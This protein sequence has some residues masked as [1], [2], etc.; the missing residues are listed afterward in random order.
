[1]VIAGPTVEILWVTGAFVGGVAIALWWVCFSRAP[2]RERRSAVVL[3]I[4]ALAATQLLNHE[5]MV[6][7]SLVSFRQACM[8]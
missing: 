4:V 1:M 2:R 7:L 8:N 3:A 5:S 6:P